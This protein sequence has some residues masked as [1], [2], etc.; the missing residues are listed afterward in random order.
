VLVHSHL[1]PVAGCANDSATAH[2]YVSEQKII[3][4]DM[5]C[6]TAFHVNQITAV[7]DI[8]TVVTQIS[9]H[10]YVSIGQRAYNAS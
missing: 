6:K 9:L 10:D 1:N 8:V 3:D 4:R 7:I 5:C 2:T